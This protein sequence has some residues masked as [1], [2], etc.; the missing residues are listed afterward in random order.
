MPFGV[1]DTK[2][3]QM[4]DCTVKEVGLE[5]TLG[6]AEARKEPI[7]NWLCLLSNPDWQGHPFRPHSVQVSSLKSQVST[8]V[9][10]EGKKR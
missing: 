3:T 1:S 8:S 9:L 2:Y 4:E 5:S 10:K 7:P 6:R